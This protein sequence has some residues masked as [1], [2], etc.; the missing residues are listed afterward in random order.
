MK[1][2]NV[3][4]KMINDFITI[5]NFNCMEHYRCY[6]ETYKN[7]FRVTDQ[8]YYSGNML[9]EISRIDC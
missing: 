4:F 8:L 5:G 3:N 7:I 9:W 6:T 2:T 1:N